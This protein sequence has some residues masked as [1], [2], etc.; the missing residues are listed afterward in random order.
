MSDAT[1]ASS[2]SS[3]ISESLERFLNFYSITAAAASVGML[4]LAQPAQAEIVITR[5]NKTV[6]LCTYTDPC[7][8]A[9]DLNKDGVTDLKIQL[10]YSLARPNTARSL[11][12]VGSNG[13]DVVGTSG[14]PYASCLVRGAKIGPSARFY[15]DGQMEA[16]NGD[17]GISHVLYGKWSGNHPDRFLGVKF[18]ISGK[19]HYGWVRVTVNSFPG[20]I[21]ATVT[22]YGYDTVAN[23]AVKA[24]LPGAAASAAEG[25]AAGRN[26]ADSA[27][28]LGMLARGV[29]GLALLR[30]K[31]ALVH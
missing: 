14:V 2:I 24:G 3:L 6:P 8:L 26:V 4:A 17:P 12:A 10:L 13:A 29:D 19:T 28:S 21:T 7:S 31:K 11:V 18:K 16:S 23:K 5:M 27:A 20:Q 15:K 9:I 25:D 30:R 1:P 22:E